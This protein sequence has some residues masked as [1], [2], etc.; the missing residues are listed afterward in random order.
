MAYFTAVLARD[1]ATWRSL[2][3]DLEDAVDVDD[4]AEEVRDVAGS[5]G[6]LLVVLEREDEWF[7][8]VR[9]DGDEPRVF[10]SDLAAVQSSRYAELL[11]LAAD[12]PAPVPAP[13]EDAEES[14]VAVAA[15][16]WAGDVE[17]LAD[18]GVS[19]DELTSAA[20]GHDAAGALA[21]VGERCEFVE[22]LEA[23]R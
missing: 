20:E 8:L 6:P 9:A 21:V 15:P 1:G 3:V 16:T 4:V 2:D 22:L 19:G 12:A 18:L 17:L 10:V 11:A 7:S 13:R 23:L 14:A 5:S